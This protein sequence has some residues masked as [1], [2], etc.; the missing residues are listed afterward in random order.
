MT[1]D[2]LVRYCLAKAGAWPDEPW[3]GDTVV[4][5]AAK[6]FVFLGT[7]GGRTI[8][9][10]CAA[11]AE[12][13]REWRDRYPDDVSVMPYLGRY[14]WN[15][16]VVGSAVPDDEIYQSIDASYDD[17]VARLPKSQRP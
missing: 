17:V 9:V 16:F 4:K 5:V 6:V 7:P 15:R 1:R 10:K 11:D 8:G 3:D 14:G 13:A 12:S 2:E